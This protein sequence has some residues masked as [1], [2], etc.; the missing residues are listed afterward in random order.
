[1]VRRLIIVALVF[2]LIP[3]FRLQAAEE[4]PGRMPA[5]ELFQ[6]IHVGAPPP[7]VDVRSRA[8]YERG[9]VPGAVHIPFWRVFGHTSEI[10]SYR[11][12]P[13]VIYCEHGPRAAIAKAALRLSGFNKIL[14]LDG[15]LS[16]WRKAGL[17]L[18]SGP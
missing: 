7:I 14:Y 12:Q 1:M 5:D 13:I 17:P 16:A 6:L 8:E 15:H 11:N 2:V 4:L 9:H 18:E 10:A 3:I